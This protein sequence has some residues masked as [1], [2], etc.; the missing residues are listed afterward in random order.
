MLH[1]QINIQHNFILTTLDVCL[2]SLVLL[3][4]VTG[5]D[6]T[7]LDLVFFFWSVPESESESESDPD[8]DDL[9]DEE[10][11]EAD[12]LSDLDSPFTAFPFFCFL[13]ELN[14]HTETTELFV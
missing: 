4:F 14:T 9:S 1:M 6:C 3:T 13:L 10:L 2:D 12:S 11:S 7:G 5:L 8:S